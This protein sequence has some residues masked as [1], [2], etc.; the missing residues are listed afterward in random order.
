MGLTGKFKI[1]SF[2]YYKAKYTRSITI[3]PH[4]TVYSSLG[5]NYYNSFGD[6]VFRYLNYSETKLI[7][8]P[9]YI[10]N[11]EYN[12]SINFHITVIGADGSKEVCYENY[13]D[14]DTRFFVY[15]PFGVIIIFAVYSA[16]VVIAIKKIK[17][18]YTV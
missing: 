4:I 14:D 15:L 8:R 12:P 10:A 1:D 5:D 9:W 17:K 18:K 13:R 2:E 11:D 16:I 3:V 6:L 7:A